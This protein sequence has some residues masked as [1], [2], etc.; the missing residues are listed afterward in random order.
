MRADDL[1][2]PAAVAEHE[3]LVLNKKAAVKQK[4][5]KRRLTCHR[6]KYQADIFIFDI[7]RVAEYARY[8]LAAHAENKNVLGAE[9]L[10]AVKTVGKPQGYLVRKPRSGDIC[11]GTFERTAVYVCR[12]GARRHAR[13]RKIYGEVG[14]IG[15]DVGNK[16]SLPRVSGSGKQPCAG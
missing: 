4:A 8:K 7:I 14:V 12:N 10:N 2:Y 11:R 3:A 6:L 13:L 15:P 5:A 16:F 1:I 9:S